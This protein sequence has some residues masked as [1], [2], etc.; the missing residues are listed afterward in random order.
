MYLE[1]RDICFRHECLCSFIWC[2][3][4]LNRL[5]TCAKELK[6]IEENDL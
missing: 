1:Q 3:L 4:L 6:R 5:D 2:S